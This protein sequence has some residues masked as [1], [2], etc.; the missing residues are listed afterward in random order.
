MR[1]LNVIGKVRFCFG[2]DLRDSSFCCA[3][4]NDSI[5]L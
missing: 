3:P 4:G 1:A 5:D 2:L